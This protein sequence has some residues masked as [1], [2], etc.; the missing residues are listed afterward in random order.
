VLSPFNGNARLKTVVVITIIPFFSNAVQFWLTD[1]VIMRKWNEEE[2]QTYIVQHS[3]E[4]TMCEKT[5]N[6]N[7]KANLS[8]GETS[9]KEITQKDILESDELNKV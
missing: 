7:T 9:K 3:V 5:A 6:A 4:N 8:F 1:N 2:V